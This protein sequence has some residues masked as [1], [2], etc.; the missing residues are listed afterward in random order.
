MPEP[1]VHVAAPDDPPGASGAEGGEQV[2]ER[3]GGSSE[4]NCIGAPVTGWSKRSSRGME[5]R[6]AGFRH[7]ASVRPRP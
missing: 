6:T 4:V 5:E 2:A 7:V 1:Y 3:S